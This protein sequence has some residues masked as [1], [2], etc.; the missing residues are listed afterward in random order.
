MGSFSDYCP[1]AIHSNLAF[2]LKVPTPFQV[3]AFPLLVSRS[4]L[5]AFLLRGF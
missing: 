3:Q 2:A 5:A 1:V 4:S